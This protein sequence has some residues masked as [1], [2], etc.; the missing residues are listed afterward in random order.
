MV[1]IVKDT[2]S[3]AFDRA[4]PSVKAKQDLVINVS[5]FVGAVWLINRYGHKL[6]V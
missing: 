6:A 1:D 2:V 4:D 3:K 5:I